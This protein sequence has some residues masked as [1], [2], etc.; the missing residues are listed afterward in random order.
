[1]LMNKACNILIKLQD[2][3]INAYHLSRRCDYE[4]ISILKNLKLF[5]KEKLIERRRIN[6]KEKINELT[7]KGKKVTEYLQNIKSLLGDTNG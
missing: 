2:G 7:D 6:K 5:E 4:Y 1:M 3:K